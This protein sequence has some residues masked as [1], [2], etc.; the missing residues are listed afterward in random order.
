MPNFNCVTLIGHLTRDTETRTI[1]DG[2]K[3]VKTGIAVN[4]WKQG[5]VMFI[6]LTAWNKTGEALEKVKKGQAVGV[7]GR[8]QLETWDDKATGTKRSKHSVTVDQVI[9]LSGGGKD[10][11]RAVEAPPASSEP[12]AEEQ[13]SGEIPF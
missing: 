4:G 11:G 7:V 5:D 9:Y 8:L 12:Q 13:S 6:D 3:V 2:K 1:Q 10:D